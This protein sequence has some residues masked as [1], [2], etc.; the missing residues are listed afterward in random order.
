MFKFGFLANGEMLSW[1]GKK[2]GRFL[3]DAGY[4][5]VE[6]IDDIFFSPDKD[7]VFRN[8]FLKDLDDAGIK[9]S[10]ML[11]QHDFVVLNKDERRAN[12]ELVKTNIEKCSKFG[13]KTV[14]CFT[15]PVPWM[16]FPV[17]VGRSVSFKDAWD[18]VFEAF[19]ETVPAAEK[20]GVK[21][22]VENVWGML[23]HDFYTNQYLQSRYDTEH[24]GVNLDISHDTL[25]GIFD[26]EFIVK[27]FGP[28]KI[29]HVHLKDAIGVAADGKFVFPLIGEGRVNFKALF[30]ALK[31]IGYDGVCSVEFESWAYRA[32]YLGGDHAPSAPL[33]RPIL[34]KFI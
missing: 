11:C 1:D 14:N 21:I 7:D 18:M 2:L 34:D 31:D 23:A 12:I 27:S 20:F 26:P 32:N 15:G 33:T 28:E 16:P 13:I 9:V 8:E 24:L 17:I 19:D 29:F 4:D 6:L 3:K 10:E 5:Y 30:Q 22:A 25:Y